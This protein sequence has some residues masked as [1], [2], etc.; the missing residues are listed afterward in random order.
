LNAGFRR[1]EVTAEGFK[2]AENGTAASH[3][4]NYGAAEVAVAI[5]GRYAMRHLALGE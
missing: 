4:I 3:Q 1:S 5:A 2:V